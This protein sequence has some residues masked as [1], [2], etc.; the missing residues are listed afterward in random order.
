MPYADEGAPPRYRPDSAC[1]AKIKVEMEKNWGQCFWRQRNKAFHSKD[2]VLHP[3]KRFFPGH[4]T[5]IDFG[6]KLA[7]RA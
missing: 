4:E 7:A 3:L 1:F 2:E 6:T 5:A